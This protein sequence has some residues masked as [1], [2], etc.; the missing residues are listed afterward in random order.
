MAAGVTGGKVTHEEV[1]DAG[2]RV[3]G[4][5]LTLLRAVLPRIDGWLQE[6]P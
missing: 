4:R 5:L 6:Q 3:R 2:E 1:L